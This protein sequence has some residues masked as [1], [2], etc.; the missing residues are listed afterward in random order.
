MRRAFSKFKWRK[1]R[2]RPIRGYQHVYVY[3][4]D[5]DVVVDPTYRQCFLGLAK[6]K[7]DS[8]PKMFIGTQGQ[9]CSVFSKILKQAEMRTLTEAF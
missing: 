6:P 5:L 8:L 4:P 2:T 3:S 9:Y 1:V 7:F